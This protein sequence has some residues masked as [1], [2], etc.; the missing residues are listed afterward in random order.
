MTIFKREADFEQAFI[1]VLID[2]GWEREVLKNK[3]EADL[4]QNWANILFENNRQRDRLND[5]PLTS[6]EMQQIIEQIKELKTPFKL[7]GFINGKTVAIKRDNENDPEHLG[8]EV[9]L[10]IYDRQEI[11]AGQSLTLLHKYF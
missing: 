10:K 11:A 4:L 8:K 2:K 7:N 6:G 5:V 1:E 9:S 3:T